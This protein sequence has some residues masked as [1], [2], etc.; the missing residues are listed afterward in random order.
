MKDRDKTKA[1][2]VE[3]L[4]HLRQRIVELEAVEIKQVR[5]ERALRESEAIN[6]SRL[7]LIQ[8]STVH[9]LDE[10]LEETLNE[11]EKHTDSLITKQGNGDSLDER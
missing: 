2:L 6:T 10:L 4:A 9:S 5:V 1:Q 11:T 8:F 3:E 7:R